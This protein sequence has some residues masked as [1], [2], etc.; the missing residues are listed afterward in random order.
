MAQNS[1][2][3][4]H[5][6]ATPESEMMYNPFKNIGPSHIAIVN[7]TIS[8]RKNNHQSHREMAEEPPQKR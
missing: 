5:V 2:I 7:Y 4:E 6:L 8:S 1:L 3:L